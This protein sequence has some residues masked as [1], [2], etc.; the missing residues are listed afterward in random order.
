M[1]LFSYPLL[2]NISHKNTN[3]IAI[4][5]GSVGSVIEKLSIGVNNEKGTNKATKKTV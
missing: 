1:Y 4:N 5:I 3:V 2:K